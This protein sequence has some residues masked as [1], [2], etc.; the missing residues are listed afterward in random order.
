MKNIFINI[1]ILILGVFSGYK[2]KQ[3]AYNLEQ[4]TLQFNKEIVTK[5]FNLFNAE[6][7]EL[8]VAEYFDKSYIQISDGKQLNY[9]D[10][11]KHVESVKR[12]VDGNINIEIEHI[13]SEGNKV[14]TIHKAKVKKINGENI[15]I[16]I[17]ALF[18][19]KDGKILRADELSFVEKGSAED[20][21]LSSTL[22]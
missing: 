4:H 20:K 7:T 13:V 22:E 11:I 8:A 14:F 10:F 15:E 2:Y 3:Y 19:I 21:K 1:I 12:T 9:N 18:Q 16:K 6:D 5:M 17:I